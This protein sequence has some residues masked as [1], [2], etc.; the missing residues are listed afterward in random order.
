M[1]RNRRS[2]ALGVRFGSFRIGF[3]G[4]ELAGAGWAGNG[5]SLALL[6]HLNARLV[7][8]AQ[9]FRVKA[10]RGSE[11]LDYHVVVLVHVG[12]GRP[13][14]VG[15]RWGCHGGGGFSDA[16]LETVAGVEIPVSCPPFFRATTGARAAS[17]FFEKVFGI[18]GF[19]AAGQRIQAVRNVGFST[20]RKSEVG[21]QIARPR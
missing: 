18:P 21:G 12:G 4:R 1:A 2:R 5:L 14:H 9:R 15:G 17:P 6:T 3:T 8:L 16:G 19:A 10:L 13:W 7:G 11:R 20:R